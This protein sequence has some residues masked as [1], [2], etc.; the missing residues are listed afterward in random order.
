MSQ[1]TTAPRVE[2]RFRAA[3]PEDLRHFVR[4]QESAEAPWWVQ[5]ENWAVV[6]SSS[7]SSFVADIA[8]QP[9]GFILYLSSP[10]VEPAS[11]SLL[12]SMLSWRRPARR[13]NRESFHCVNILHVSVEDAW[14]RRGIGHA[15]LT[16]VQR[17]F[18][19]SR[20]IFQVTVPEGNLP[21]QLFLK[22]E[23]YKA[24]AVVR[25]QMS[26]DDG[27]VMIRRNPR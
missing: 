19:G 24:A 27:Y 3:R 17:R 18:L 9:V 23:G 13:P 25:S 10:P 7:H 14:R 22:K 2:P 21:M 16:Q 12:Q 6:H 11:R 26:G 15:L 1:I 4:M 5:P 8:G 20:D